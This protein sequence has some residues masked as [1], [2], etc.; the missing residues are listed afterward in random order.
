MKPR[1]EELYQQA[2]RNIFKRNVEGAFENIKHGLELF[3]D[4]TKLLLL[5]ATLFRQQNDYEN[6]LNDLEKAS[7]F[8]FVDGLER[9][10]KMQIGLTYNAMG[11]SLFQK[12]KYHDSVTIFNEALNFVDQD[13]GVYIN[14]GDAYRELQKFN[15]ALSD[16]HYALDLGGQDSKINIRL[17]LTHYALGV[18]CFNEKDYEG[19]KIEFSRSI[20]YNDSMPEVFLNRARACTEL[21]LIENS[22]SDIERTLELQPGHPIANSLI[23]N[24]NRDTKPSFQNG[25]FQSFKNY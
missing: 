15:L 20:D 9:N 16:Y 22:Y 19:A 17:A 4:M 25:K 7:K 10:V 6:A 2:M 24:F 1:A 3:R 8:M 5:R 23:Q 14:R 21:G 12:K 13:S 18:N 11:S